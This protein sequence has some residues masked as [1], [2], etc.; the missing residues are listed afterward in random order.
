M[1]SGERYKFGTLPLLLYYML[2]I[3]RQNEI[4]IA[5]GL[6]NCYPAHIP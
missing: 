3:C 4:E 2:E 5:Y 6:V 1:C